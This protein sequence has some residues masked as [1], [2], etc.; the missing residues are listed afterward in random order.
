MTPPTRPIRVLV[1]D[2]SATMRAL[3][4]AMLASDPGFQVVGEAVDGAEAIAKAV[5]LR[6][7]LISMDI[8]MPVIDG[9]EATKEIM[10]QAPT[11]IIIV[12]A[13]A[14]GADMSL[15]LSATQAGALTVLP[16]PEDPNA[17]GFAQQRSHLLMMARAMAAVKVVR[18]AG[19]GG[20]ETTPR[21]SK[22]EA[23]QVKLVAIGTSTGGPP[24]V[25]RILLDI[26]RNLAA[27]VVVVQH[28]AI[29]FMQGLADWLGANVGLKVSIATAGEPLLKGVVYLAPDDTHLG[30]TADNRAQLSNRAAI[31]GFRPSVD[32]L[33]RSCAD[34]HGAGLLAVILT[35]MGQD[36]VDGLRQ[37][38]KSVV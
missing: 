31:G 2:D 32:H 16:K 23:G 24:A 38:R 9:L 18:R 1:V 29:G 14:A 35:G 28:M 15:A 25:H 33:F 6:P 21:S 10:R 37:D 3:L 34:A 22:L 7:D 20:R 11:P 17:P 26:G 19:A 12:S 8:H 30:V 13:A 5:S 36:G 4:V 27:P